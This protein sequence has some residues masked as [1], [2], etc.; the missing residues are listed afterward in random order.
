M[1]LKVL[2]AIVA[3]A[4]G[5]LAQTSAPAPKGDAKPACCA[6]ADC[7][8]DGAACCK[9]GADCCKGGHCADCKD[10]KMC[11]RMAKD[12]KGGGCAG[13]ASGK[14]CMG[15]K[16]PMMSKD[17]KTDAKAGCAGCCGGHAEHAGM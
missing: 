8:K 15:G 4:V 5:M 6:G 14:G 12:G 9:Q 11:D 16:C 1:K 2:I 13:M 3:L 17:K 7:C 10:A